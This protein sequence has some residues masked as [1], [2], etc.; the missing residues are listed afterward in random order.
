MFKNVFRHLDS[1][2]PSTPLT[3]FIF[4]IFSFLGPH[5]QDM[6]VPGLR[7]QL[8]LQLQ[9]TATT[10]ATRDQNHICDLCRSFR[11]CWIL[12]PLNGARDGTCILTETSWV[13]NPLSHNRNS[14][15][16]TLLSPLSR[17]EAPRG[18]R[19]CSGSQRTLSSW[20]KIPESFQLDSHSA[21]NA[22]LTL[23]SD[24]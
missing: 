12:N 8:E 16:C 11:Q 22:E 23:R 14:P 19:I 13:L 5:L 15:F 10:T 18:L 7:V 17:G 4:I 6:E 20:L 24:S 3:M 1:P 21:L 9:D 2:D